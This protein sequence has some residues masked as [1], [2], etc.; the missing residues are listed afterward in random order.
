MLNRCLSRSYHPC[1][2]AGPWTSILEPEKR[3]R[4]FSILQPFAFQFLNF[5]LLNQRLLV[6]VSVF[7]RRGVT[8]A[9]LFRS[10]FLCV[11]LF[12]FFV[13]LS[14]FAV[15]LHGQAQLHY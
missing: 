13:F 1:F 8:A 14:F 12:L 15:L 5:E 2:S 11:I 3:C 4:R 6:V 9:C 10:V 7:V